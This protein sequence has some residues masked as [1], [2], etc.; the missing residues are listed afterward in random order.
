[1]HKHA[2]GMGKRKLQENGWALREI[3]ILREL[4]K[5]SEKCRKSLKTVENCEKLRKCGK[6]RNL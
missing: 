5:T 2:R 3:A 4:R 1:M 6:L